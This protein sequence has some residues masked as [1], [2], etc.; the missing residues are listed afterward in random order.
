MTFFASFLTIILV[1]GLYPSLKRIFSL[2]ANL[3]LADT[4]IFGGGPMVIPLLRE[5]VVAEG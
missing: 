2:F 5:Y 1:R 4:I 3:Y